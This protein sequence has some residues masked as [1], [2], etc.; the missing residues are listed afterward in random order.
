MDFTIL[1]IISA[2]IGVLVFTYLI[3]FMRKKGVIKTEDLLFVAKLFN[4]S[5]L[6]IDELNLQKEDQIKQ[7]GKIVYD[8][9]AYAIT[10]SDNQVNLHEEC[11]KY[12]V[13]LCIEFG[14]EITKQ[15]E[16]IIKNLITIGLTNEMLYD[17][18]NGEMSIVGENE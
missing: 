17:R 15:R 8:S 16:Q 5:M 14:I 13:E 10:L 9:I 4:L 7:I 6:I 1:Y 12:V 2:I 3:A 11:Y 18:L